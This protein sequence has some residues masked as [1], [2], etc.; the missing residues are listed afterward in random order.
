MI[1]HLL[2]PTK[3]HCPLKT[4]LELGRNNFRENFEWMWQFFTDH[5]KPIADERRAFWARV[6]RE[7]GAKFQTIRQA[8]TKSWKLDSSESETSDR[9]ASEPKSKRPR[10]DD[11]TT[12]QR[13]WA[14]DY[15]IIEYEQELREAHQQLRQ[16]FNEFCPKLPPPITPATLTLIICFDGARHLCTSSASEEYVRDNTTDTGFGDSVEKQSERIPFSNFRAM[17]RALQLLRLAD[18]I[19]R[20]FGL[21]TDTPSRLHDIQPRW[22]EDRSHRWINLPRPGM[23]R[24]DSI[25]MFTSID[26]HSQMTVPNYAISDHKKVAEVERLLKFGRAGWYSWYTGKSESLPKYRYYTKDKIRD[27]AIAKLLD[28]PLDAELTFSNEVRQVGIKPLKP[29]MRL[30]LLALL[31]PRLAIT[32]GPYTSEAVQMVSSH[33]A[34]LLRTDKDRH[35]NKTFYPPEPILAEASAKITK[36]IGWTPLVRGL[37]DLIQKGIVSAGFRGELLTK[38]LLLMAMDDTPKPDLGDV[39]SPYWEHTQPVK[40]IDFLNNWLAAPGSKH[41][42]FSDALKDLKPSSGKEL[43]RFLDGH[44]FFTHFVRLDCNVSPRAIV[45]AWNQGA[46]IMAKEENHNFD[47]V[48]P[49]MLAGENGAPTPTF[50]PLYNEWSEDE[51]KRACSNVSCIFI[52]SKNYKNQYAAAEGCRPTT[53]NYEHFEMFNTSDVMFFSIA[54]D[55]GPYQSRRETYVNIKGLGEKNTLAYRQFKIVLKGLGPETYQCLRENRSADTPDTL[56]VTMIDDVPGPHVTSMDDVTP[57][58]I[59]HKESEEDGEQEDEVLGN[60]DR[61][62]ATRYLRMLR[63]RKL[64]YLPDE[65]AGALRAITID[66]LGLAYSG[67][68]LE[69]RKEVHGGWDRARSTA[70]K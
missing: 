69:I 47:H 15:L 40:V 24:F 41:R 29:K 37:Y 2:R 14:S 22:L 56:D 42:S 50:G 4:Q 20:V 1:Q 18:P 34:V 39:E 19:P 26:A 13:R 60:S 66:S 27:V 43:Q 16:S 33:L 32:A 11:V 44:V 58:E 7:A 23:Y 45:C 12:V 64:N 8:A 70:A 38:V 31:A 67:Q 9:E 55:F 54:Q 62:K 48:I 51:L 59:D 63:H 25:N 17:R 28:I 3:E 49:V 21:F 65:L 53:K 57:M 10:P 30:R 35:F 6:L 36:T 52:N 5:D 61:A 68:A 46:A